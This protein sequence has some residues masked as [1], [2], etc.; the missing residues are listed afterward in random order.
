MKIIIQANNFF[1]L[2]DEEFNRDFLD[3]LI[4]KL[5][6]ITEVRNYSFNLNKNKCII[7]LDI[8]S[9]EKIKNFIKK[10]LQSPHYAIARLLSDSQIDFED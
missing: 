3:P 4:K 6:A 8:D 9:N 1:Q 7:D 2:N 10:Q 5:K